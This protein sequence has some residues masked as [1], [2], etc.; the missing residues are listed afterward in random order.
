VAQ[1]RAKTRKKAFPFGGLIWTL[2]FEPNSTRLRASRLGAA[3]T[4]LAL[5][6]RE[7]VR[8]QCLQAFSGVL[9]VR[10]PVRRR[11]ERAE[12]EWR[13]QPR[14]I[15]ISQARNVSSQLPEGGGVVSQGNLSVRA[16]G[17]N[18]INGFLRN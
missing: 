8:K 18:E 13:R 5:C 1:K 3:R 4:H 11:A 12:W 10:L 6:T 14:G 7:P 2:N 16:C 9:P 17:A 15:E